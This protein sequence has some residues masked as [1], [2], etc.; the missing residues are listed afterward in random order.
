M[1]LLLLR[2]FLKC[3]R[4]QIYII[5]V[6]HGGADLRLDHAG[7]VGRRLTPNLQQH[8]ARFATAE[9]AMSAIAI[10]WKVEGRQSCGSCWHKM[11]SGEIKESGEF[12]EMVWVYGTRGSQ[13][14][15]PRW[16]VWV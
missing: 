5:S 11:Q 2:S 13:S 14:E 1:G 4:N 12:N 6:Q 8:P 15:N 3:K 7:L 9:R 16:Q 10:D